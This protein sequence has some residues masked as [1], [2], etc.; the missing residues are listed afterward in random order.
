MEQHISIGYP[1]ISKLI[2]CSNGYILNGGIE[3]FESNDMYYGDGFPNPAFWL[4][5]NTSIKKGIE[6]GNSEYINSSYFCSNWKYY[7]YNFHTSIA[8][9][10]F[11]RP[12]L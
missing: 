10:W 11:N 7:R 2:G 3:F 6:T 8:L 5:V 4:T 1:N 9:I 12:N